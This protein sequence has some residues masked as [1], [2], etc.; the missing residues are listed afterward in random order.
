MYD[1]HLC[2]L[3]CP[4][5]YVF[6]LSRTAYSLRPLLNPISAQDL[7]AA[8]EMC[9]IH[10]V[11]KWR[12][13]QPA[14]RQMV[15]MMNTMQGGDVSSSS[16]DDEMIQ[17]GVNLAEMARAWQESSARTTYLSEVRHCAALPG[18]TRSEQTS[19]MK[20]SNELHR[21]RTHIDLLR[22]RSPSTPHTVTKPPVIIHKFVYN[23]GLVPFIVP[24]VAYKLC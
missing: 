9:C 18:M 22:Q 5:P 16:T 11:R 14:Y 20:V 3:P 19:R 15:D 7:A 12:A 23:H 10:T 24:H 4:A 6:H 13:A 21:V 1:N 17:N 8:R 2:A